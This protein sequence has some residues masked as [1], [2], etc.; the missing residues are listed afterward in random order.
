MSITRRSFLGGSLAAAGLTT[1]GSAA[2]A[3]ALGIDSAATTAALQS[4]REVLQIARVYISRDT[5]HLLNGFDDTHEVG[6]GWVEVLLW[7]GDLAKLVETGLRYDIT[8][9]DVALRDAQLRANSTGRPADLA[10]QPGETDGDYRVLD[11]YNA[12]MQMLADTYPT[13]CRMFE[14]P[15]RSHEGRTIY[16]LEIAEGVDVEVGNATSPEGFNGT[17]RDGRPVFYNDGIHHAREWPAAEVPI[18][19][20]FD[21]CEGY[22][23]GDPV[24]T[25]LVKHSRNII[26]PV[27]NVDGFV[28]TREFPAE[29]GETG[30]PNPL[31]GQNG[32]EAILLGGQ[33]AYWRKNRRKLID[34]VGD[35]LILN[36][37][38]PNGVGAYGIDPNR[39]YSYQ[40]GGD[41]SSADINDAT[42]RGDAPFSEPES[43]NVRWIHSE[44][45]CVAGITH[46]TSGDLILWAWGDTLEDAPD[47]ALAARAGIACNAYNGYR[48]GRS[49]DLYV[50][51][52]TC[53][54]WTYGTFGS[55]SYTFE[56]AGSSFHPAY[57]ETVPTMYAKNR[58]ALILLN[59]LTAM[60]PEHRVFINNPG[61]ENGISVDAHQA[62]VGTIDMQVAMPDRTVFHEYYA[63]SALD[64]ANGVYFAAVKGQLVDADGNGVKGSV[65]IDKRFDNWLWRRGNG[66][67]PTGE[68]SAPETL[69]T[70]IATDDDGNF[71]WAIY[72]SRQPNQDSFDHGVMHISFVPDSG[73]LGVAQDLEISRGELRDFGQL[74]VG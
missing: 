14:L 6:D 74:V 23:G 26:V 31:L 50:T 18:M 28:Y 37:A 64:P 54:D 39:N 13:I 51:T 19:W 30:L 36:A 34:Q 35:G 40:W 57:P 56:H 71:Q 47:V 55:M 67:N 24:M 9:P 12:D 21:L 29:T 62:L 45:H 68:L 7:P 72:P 66:G 53:S 52:G 1:L 32:S 46:H 61:Q 65:R 33:G 59:E 48:P 69:S 43:N 17:G 8:V 2:A 42:Y 3:S 70:E 63:N 60:F 5:A 22:A 38:V 16:G 73:G 15:F 25:N 49:I 44:F 20:A 10:L 27:V 41:G 58:E 11:D 4:A